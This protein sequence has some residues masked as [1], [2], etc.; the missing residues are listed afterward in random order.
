MSKSLMY[1]ASISLEALRQGEILKGVV[2]YTPILTEPANEKNIQLSRKLH[3]YAIII[4]Q[5]CDLDWDYQAR[6]GQGKQHKLLNS[7]ILC[8]VYPAEDIR[9]DKNREINSNAWKQIQSNQ[10]RQFH[11]FEKV[12][13]DCELGNE[14]LPELTVDFKQVF[15]IEA[16][17]LYHQINNKIASRH[18]VLECRYLEHFS[19]RYCSYQGRVALPAEYQ[20]E[21]ENNK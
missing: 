13:S 3:P 14:G 11:F 16:E 4:S 7:I 19:Q 8:E 10:N 5:D 20:S 12:P 18:T 21:K 9:F 1:R 15:S 17:I 2:Q 6:Q